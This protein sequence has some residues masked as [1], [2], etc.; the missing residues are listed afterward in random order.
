MNRGYLPQKPITMVTE[1]GDE[2]MIEAVSQKADAAQATAQNARQMILNRD[3]RLQAVEEQ[4]LTL[5]GLADEYRQRAAESQADRQQ[6]HADIASL[7][8]DLH[9]EAENR[10][11]QDTANQVAVSA[12]NAR[13]E[14]IQLTPGPAGKDGTPGKDGR[15][16]SNGKDGANGA[17]GKSAY[18]LARDA[19]YGGTETQWLATLK[20]ADGARGPQGLQGTAGKDA[21]PAVVQALTTR[22]TTLETGKP[23]ALGIAVTPTLALL[24]TVDIVL[25]L[26]RT[27]PDTAYTIELARSTN[28]TPDM[29]TL[30]TKTVSSV[31]YTLKA[32][33]A[34]GAG[35]LGVIARY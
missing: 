33:L 19:G 21:D 16:G 10:A 22:V 2:A 3:P 11:N 26:S 34:L 12:L 35:T 29:L 7:A 14:Q 13:L 4:Q 31:T 1:N 20:G 17:D 23:I 25:N 8:T 9:D 24:A 5:Q 28:I 30:K 18:Q 27:M 15:D 6:L 32:V